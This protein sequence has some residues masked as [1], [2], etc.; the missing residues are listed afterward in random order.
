MSQ[1]KYW[2]KKYK[3]AFCVGGFI[4]SIVASWQFIGLSNLLAFPLKNLALLLLFF[5]IGGLI[6]VFLVAMET[7]DNKT[8][9]YH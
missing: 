4:A 2:T 5:I 6:S 7:L 8:T 9:G 3:V 1:P